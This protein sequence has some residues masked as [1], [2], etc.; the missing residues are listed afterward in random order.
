M[1]GGLYHGPSLCG[2]GQDTPPPSSFGLASIQTAGYDAPADVCCSLFADDTLLKGRYRAVKTWY[3]YGAGGQGVET[4]DILMQMNTALGRQDIQPVFLVDSPE[5]KEVAGH[6]VIGLDDATPGSLVSIAVGE[7]EIRHGLHKKALQA[8]LRLASI[9]SPSAFVS[10]L[11][12]LGDGVIIAPFCSIQARARIGENVLVNTAA[13]VGHDA[14]VDSD[15][16]LSFTVNLGGATQVGSRSYLGMGALVRERL[17][18]GHSTIVGMGSVVCADV[19]DEVVC[20]GNPAKV[21]C[22]NTSKRV[23]K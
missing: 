20:V 2:T 10:P 18:I 16:V 3:I 8:G 15:S 7:P 6:P 1:V 19:P 14:F 5:A 22:R 17:S 9:I 11:A 12:T 4:L 23:F 21:S 13:I